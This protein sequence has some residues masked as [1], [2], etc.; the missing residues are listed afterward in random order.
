MKCGFDLQI[1]TAS[2][3]QQKVARH[4]FI[5]V[6]DIIKHRP[7]E[8][9]AVGKIYHDRRDAVGAEAAL[10]PDI[11]NELYVFPFLDLIIDVGVAERKLRLKFGARADAVSLHSPNISSKFVLR[12]TNFPD[13]A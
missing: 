6:I 4:H 10:N 5:I 12:Y 9:R 2:Q 8:F 3:S 11:A 13:M 7:L 1:L